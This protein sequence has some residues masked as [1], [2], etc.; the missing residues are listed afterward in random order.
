M[1]VPPPPPPAGSGPGYGA[2]GGGYG[3]G[4]EQP[5]RGVVVLVLGIVGIATCFFCLIGSVLG[6]IAL[7]LGI[8]ALR[9]ID[10]QPGRYANRGQVLA[11]TICGGI[12]VAL[13]ILALIVV[14]A[15]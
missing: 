10:A 15:T 9:E 12:A 7:V 2:E 8:V 14:A 1:S 4:P 5:P 6:V 13:G 3:T 11:G